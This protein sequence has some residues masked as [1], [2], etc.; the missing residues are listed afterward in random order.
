MFTP[1]IFLLLAGQIQEP[2]EFYGI[3]L[4]IVNKPEI[5]R[6]LVESWYDR[7]SV[8]VVDEDSRLAFHIIEELE[9]RRLHLNRVFKIK[10]RKNGDVPGFVL[11]R[12]FYSVPDKYLET[13]R[14]Y[15]ALE[16]LES[17]LFYHFTLSKWKK[18]EKRLMEDWDFEEWMR[19]IDFVASLDIKNVTINY[20]FDYFYDENTPND[21]ISIGDK[22]ATLES[23]G[24]KPGPLPKIPPKPKKKQPVHG[25]NL[26]D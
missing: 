16:Y 18:V 15:E 13:P 9:M 5:K 23:I 1:L 11:N 21:L 8:D 17:E 4:E 2:Y 7:V 3:K 26:N 14:P 12:I 19:K 20:D 6:D 10:F 25:F 22:I 24:Y